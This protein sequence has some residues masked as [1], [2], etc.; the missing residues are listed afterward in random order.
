[1]Y[2]LTRPNLDR[3]PLA[4]MF[5]ACASA[6]GAFLYAVSR[7]GASKFRGQINSCQE[8]LIPGENRETDKEKE[9]R[10]FVIR[11]ET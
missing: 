5:C 4:F 8:G 6:A 10:R 11:R 1:M 2:V 3:R 9:S 7:S